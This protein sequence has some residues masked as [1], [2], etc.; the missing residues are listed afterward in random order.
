MSSFPSIL[1]FWVFTTSFL[2]TGVPPASGAPHASVRAQDAPSGRIE[3]VAKA[4][5]TG[6]SLAGANVAL[7]AAGDSTLVGGV[8]TGA[9]GAFVLKNLSMGTYRVVVSFAGYAQKAR[10]V[11]LSAARPTRDLGVVILAKTI[12]KWRRQRS[13]RSVRRSPSKAARG[14]TT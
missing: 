1:L 3:G 13:P 10:G 2:L 14:S 6:R 4:A 11:Q 8:A 5:D 12:P 7:R 9:D